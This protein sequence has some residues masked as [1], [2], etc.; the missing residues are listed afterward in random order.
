MLDLKFSWA[1]FIQ[2]VFF[3]LLYLACI[4]AFL[5]NAPHSQYIPL[6]MGSIFCTSSCA[7]FVAD[8][9]FK[10]KKIRP[11]VR[12]IGQLLLGLFYIYFGFIY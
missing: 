12:T 8:V 3:L 4:L 5:L 10:N 1:R 6:T 9:D 7:S 11:T 2:D